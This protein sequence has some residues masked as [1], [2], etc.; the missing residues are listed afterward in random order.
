MSH[1]V[2]DDVATAATIV[3][4]VR[5]LGPQLRDRAVEA[6]RNCRVSDETIA[7]LDATGAFNIGV[8][9]EFGG[10]EL[11]VVQQL[12]VIEEV[13]KWDGSCGCVVWAGSS[14][15]W[16]PAGS[17]PRGQASLYSSCF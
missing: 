7:D 3:Q 9:A 4:K 8:P 14:T 1:T 15:H 10:L 12:D 5:E 11:S 16:I 13:S 6:E 17:G 2:T